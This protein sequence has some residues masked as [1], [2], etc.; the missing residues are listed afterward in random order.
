MPLL[1]GHNAVAGC[2]VDAF[3]L[4]PDGPWV[5]SP[6]AEDIAWPSLP[7]CLTTLGSAGHEFIGVE[8]RD[9]AW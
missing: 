7:D 3:Q 6:Y 8:P 5:R 9:S 4:P 1:G 2:T